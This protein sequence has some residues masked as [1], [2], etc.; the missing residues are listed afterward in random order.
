MTH[1]TAPHLLE[2]RR[3]DSSGMVVG[4]VCPYGETS[5]MTEWVQGERFVRGAFTDAV[6]AVKAG[7]RYPVVLD[8]DQA[9]E[10]GTVVHLEETVKGLVAGMRF[11]S[12]GMGREVADMAL[13]HA[14]PLS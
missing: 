10:I 13:R 1:T 14:V 5:A 12:S 9:H 2:V 6:L 11:R 7:Q 8:H 4:V 3:A